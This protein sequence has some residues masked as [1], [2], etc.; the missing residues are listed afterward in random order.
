[1]SA[2]VGSQ[3]R[4]GGACVAGV[5]WEEHVVTQPQ[6]ADVA[7][8]AG[9]VF[10]V[11]D[12]ERPR[13][14]GGVLPDPI[15][16]VRDTALLVDDQVLHDIEILRARL[17]REMPGCVAV[18]A[19]IVH[20]HVEVRASPPARGQ[21]AEGSERDGEGRVATGPDVH[22]AALDAV[23]RPV[24]DFD[25]VPPGREGEDVP[26][27]SVKVAVLEPALGAVETVV[28]M[29]PCVVG[30]VAAPV[31]TGDRHPRRPRDDETQAAGRGQGGA[32]LDAERG[33]PSSGQ[34]HDPE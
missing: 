30:G 32:P 28:G 11:V 33:A 31:R 9:V 12:D 1:M 25:R 6:Q 24:G 2:L 14:G 20:V 7:P 23:C 4:R 26:A 5:P 34:L 10:L 21:V 18:G 3:A 16:D 17:E 19:A 22:R 13:S 8:D 27:R 29:H 15:P